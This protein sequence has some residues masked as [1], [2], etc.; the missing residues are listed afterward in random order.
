MISHV[1]YDSEWYS[2][3][4]PELVRIVNDNIIFAKLVTFIKKRSSLT[5]DSYGIL[6]SLNHSHTT[7]T[8]FI[9]NYLIHDYLLDMIGMILARSFVWLL[10]V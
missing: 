9:P 7:R 3:H 5:Q 6:Q 4:F 8:A 10:T 2:Y 1:F